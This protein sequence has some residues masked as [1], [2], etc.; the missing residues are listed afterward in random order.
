MP[1]S[2]QNNLDPVSEKFLNP[3]G[4]TGGFFIW[5]IGVTEASR[6][7]IAVARVQLPDEPLGE[8]KCKV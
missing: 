3:P 2:G 4:K 1:D 6:I 7:G 5:L 8:M